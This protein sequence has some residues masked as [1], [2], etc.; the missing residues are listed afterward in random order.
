MP[1]IRNDETVGFQRW[2]IGAYDKRVTWEEWRRASHEPRKIPDKAQGS[3]FKD[4]EP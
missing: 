1:F 3:L 4:G 2:V